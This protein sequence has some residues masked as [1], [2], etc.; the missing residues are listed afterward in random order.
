MSRSRGTVALRGLKPAVG[1]RWDGQRPGKRSTHESIGYR[2]A[3]AQRFEASDVTV[4]ARRTDV[5]VASI[6]WG[7]VSVPLAI[8]LL[9]VGLMAPV[10]AAGMLLVS[11]AF[12]VALRRWRLRGQGV[13]TVDDGHVRLDGRSLTT[14]RAITSGHASSLDGRVVAR[15]VRGR[16]GL[17]IDLEMATDED[18][19]KLLA[20]LR[21]DRDHRRARMIAAWGVPRNQWSSAILAVVGALPF[22]SAPVLLGAPGLVFT[23]LALV[24]MAV[25]TLRCMTT[26]TVGADG[27]FAQRWLARPRFVRYEDIEATK[28]NGAQLEIAVKNGPPIEAHLGGFGRWDKALYGDEIILKVK[29]LGEQ[30]AAAKR[31]HEDRANR[32]AVDPTHL[33]RNG[34]AIDEWLRA[35]RTTKEETAGFRDHALPTDALWDIVSDGSAAPTARAGAAIALRSQLDDDGRARLRIAAETCA[36]PKL[37]IALQSAVEEDDDRLTESL[38]GLDEGAMPALSARR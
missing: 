16:L 2:S 8:A 7:V 13:L 3:V 20:A 14:I 4:V 12:I 15:L 25:M 33:R 36:S 31:A 29:A 17:D 11:G 22:V 27:V 30:V 37:R 9:A 10:V 28:T 6:A 18:A 5:V 23:F 35:L 34:R 21:I 38:I 1:N 32:A 26:I 19:Q 24:Y